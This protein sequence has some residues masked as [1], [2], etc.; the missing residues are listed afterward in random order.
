MNILVTGAAGFVGRHLVA[1]L[2]SRGHQV[3]AVDLDEGRARGMPWFDQCRFVACN[4]HQPMASPRNVFGEAEAV[5][6]L[7]WPGLPNYKALFHYEVNLPADYRFLKSL[8][9]DG[10]SHLLVA[11]T[12]LEY[13]MQSGCLREGMSTQPT[14]SYALAKDFLRKFLE[15]L[16][17]E[18]PF[19]LQWAR[20]FYM[21]G[22]GQNS[23]SL[24]SMLNRAIEQDDL[25]FNMSGGEQLRDYLPVQQVASYLA[26]IVENRDFDGVV[27]VCS[28]RPISVRRLVESRI[29]ERHAGIQL[30]L[31]HYPYPDYEPM[32]FWGDTTRLL[33]ITGQS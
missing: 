22:E 14:N 16:Q 13:G 8:I 33:A 31:G 15:M 26:A 5:I 19:T 3:T 7:A 30:N 20:L 18:I 25:T 2:L 10:Y 12:C 24:L 9:T 6:H 23:N 1:V 11:G 32:A 17:T 4:V 27:N 28:G 21:H 29:A